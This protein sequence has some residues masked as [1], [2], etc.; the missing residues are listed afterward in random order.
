LVCV[1]AEDGLEAERLTAAVLADG[2]TSPAGHARARPPEIEAAAIRTAAD[3]ALA[4]DATVYV[5]HLSSAAGLAEV[6]AARGRGAVVLAETCPQY[7]FLTDEALGRAPEDAIDFMCTPPLRTDVDRGALWAA[8]ADGDLQAVST[9]HCPF[10]RADRRRGTAGR[11]VEDFTQV[12]GGLPGIETR[13]SLLYQGVREGG[14]SPERW[15]DLIAGAPARLFGL[16]YRKGSLEAGLDADVVLF[17]PEAERTLDATALH[18]R[19]DHSPYAGRR[20]R[21]WPA[22]TISRGTIV[23][24]A[25]EPVDVDPRRGR[26]IP[27][28]PPGAPS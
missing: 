23:A 19:T 6:G 24:R 9:D 7:L 22:V 21:G 27:R 10:T 26:Y 4:A 3:L 25:G 8:L 5:V 1:H 11:G 15:V 16:A 28:R 14:L 13:V 17:D 2:E 20:I 12:P 18:M